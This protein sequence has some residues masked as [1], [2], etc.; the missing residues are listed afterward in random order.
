MRIE[1]QVCNFILAK[2]LKELG[3]KQQSLFYWEFNKMKG[4]KNRL[5]LSDKREKE[6]EYEDFSK[7]YIS[8]FSAAEL[9]RELPNVFISYRLNGS[10]YMIKI[11]ERGKYSLKE[12]TKSKNEADTRAKMLIIIN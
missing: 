12:E 10:Y 7:K 6:Y 5:I 2:Q 8:A 4:I 3:I 11:E 9:G 1:D